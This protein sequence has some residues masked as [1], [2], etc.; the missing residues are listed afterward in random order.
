MDILHLRVFLGVADE[1]HFGRAADRLHLAQPYLSRTVRALEAELGQTLFRRTTRRVELTPAGNALLPH[2]REMVALDGRARDA[3]TAAGEGRS[4]RVRVA[5]AG[6]SAQVFVG[7]LARASRE[8]HPLIDLDLVPGRYGATAMAALH[9]RDV[10]LI[11]AWFA[12][13]PLGVRSRRVLQDRCVI[14]LPAGHP[15]A[16]SEGVALTDLRDEPLVGLPE[17]AGSMVRSMLV[18]RCQ[19][20]GFMPRFVQSAPDSWTC[21]ALVSAGVG[22]HLTTAGA[23]EHMALDGI[24][25][26]E[27]VGN[28]PPVSIHLI[29]QSDDD[30]VLHRV[31]RTSLRALPGVAV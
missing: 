12:E 21:M 10:D 26:R 28:L 27:I 29:W 7:R 5:F 24:D 8:E 18:A 22:L 31:L 2:A 23:V 17:T 25:V 1:L 14:A 13:P 3:V 15:L 19:E 30:P 9:R 16:A 4:G 11:F 6:P 20:A